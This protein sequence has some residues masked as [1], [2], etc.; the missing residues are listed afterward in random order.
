MHS[1]IGSRVM[2]SLVADAKTWKRFCPSL[3]I[4][5]V[6]H[7]FNLE[8]AKQLSTPINSNMHLLKDDSAEDKQEMKDIPYHELVG[9]LNWLAVG[10]QPDIAF[11]VGQLA[12]FLENPGQ[13]HWDAAKRVVRYLKTTK[14]LRLTYRGGDKHGF[15]GY[16]DADGATQDHRH[17]VSGFAVLV[18]G[19]AISW[20]SKKQELVTLSMMEAEYVSTTHAAKELI[21]FR[22]LIEEIFRPLSHPIVLHLDNQLAI[23]LAN[24]E[25]Q[26]HTCTKHI[27]IC[28]HFIKFAIQNRTIVLIYCPTKN[29]IAD[30]VTKPIPLI[31]HKYLTHDLGLIL[32]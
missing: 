30:I 21:W 25:G 23:T 1:M 18:D 8:D 11:A 28:Y 6:V 17:V 31:K 19:G 12:Q 29:M 7:R 2:K 5:S 15:E 26:F 32:V 24:S 13:V 10:S 22:C 3:Y 14:E 27:N 4:N 9:A 16:S 20:S